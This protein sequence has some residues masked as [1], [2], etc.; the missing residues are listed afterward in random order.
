MFRHFSLRGPWGREL[1][2][3]GRMDED[4]RPT[5][6][7]SPRDLVHLALGIEPRALVIAAHI[8]TPWYG[9]LGARSGFDSLSE[10]FGDAAPHVGA[11]ETG[12]SSDPEMNWAVPDLDG[13]ALVSFSDAHSGPRLGREVTVF[14]GDVSYAALAGSLR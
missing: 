4:G 3:F 7:L 1:A 5:V 11:A 8:W 9:A 14:L 10:C 13:F 6:R 12:L 2:R